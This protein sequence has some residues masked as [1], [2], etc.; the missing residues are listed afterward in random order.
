[1]YIFGSSLLL[2][3][4]IFLL[5]GISKIL[6]LK[7]YVEGIKEYEI[8]PHSVV[9]SF[10]VISI[11]IEFFV[12]YAYLT[13]K[14]LKFASLASIILLGSY[15]IAVLINL[16]RKKEMSC[17][18]FE[19]F[20]KSQ[21]T[22][23]TLFRVMILLMINCYIFYF[24][25]KGLFNYSYLLTIKSSIYLLLMIMLLLINELLQRGLELYNKT[26]KEYQY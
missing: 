8:L 16:L 21:L 18:C 15:G 11:L 19:S 10:A 25:P 2:I 1:M 6:N 26:K 14:Y 17:H 20:S 13:T 23:S 4:V 22:I 9:P 3:S 24:E 7:G 12:V 5:S